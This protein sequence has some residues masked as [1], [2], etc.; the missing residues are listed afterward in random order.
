MGVR[1]ESHVR[2]RVALDAVRAGLQQDELGL[3]FA[4]VRQNARPYDVESRIVRTGRNRDVELGAGRCAQSD[5]L[6]AAGA[7]VQVA[8]V[9]MDVGEDQVRVALEAVVNAVAVVGIY[10]HVSN[11]LQAVIPP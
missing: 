2:D 4:Q 5:F 9:L 6:G 10:V 7:G 3:V 1:R 11:A 8:T